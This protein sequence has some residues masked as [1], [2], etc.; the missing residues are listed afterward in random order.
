MKKG[1]KVKIKNHDKTG[2][3]GSSKAKI[4]T[5]RRIYRIDSGNYLS[6]IL[7]IGNSIYGFN[8]SNIEII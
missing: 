8:E 4:G 1:D 2:I 6:I 3:L 5:V 7:K